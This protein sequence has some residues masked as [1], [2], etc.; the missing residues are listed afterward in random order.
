MASVQIFKDMDKDVMD[1]KQRIKNILYGTF[2]ADTLELHKPETDTV[3]EALVNLVE[4]EKRKS[5]VETL[6]NMGPRDIKLEVTHE[7]K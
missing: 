6:V 4:E 1:I 7:E 2:D 3:I 5:E